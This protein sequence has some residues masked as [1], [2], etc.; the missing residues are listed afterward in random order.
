MQK[1]LQHCSN[2][3]PRPWGKG[4]LQ[5]EEEQILFGQP[6]R[7]LERLQQEPCL[8]FHSQS[9]QVL[10]NDDSCSGKISTHNCH[11]QTQCYFTLGNTSLMFMK[12]IRAGTWQNQ[13]AGKELKLHR[14][15]LKRQKSR[16]NS[17]RIIG[18][19]I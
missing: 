11:F 8:A 2:N 16:T 5:I 3:I 1:G 14:Y 10:P 18:F 19:G 13:T 4:G 12:L 17:H 6:E 15:Q 7:R 9:R